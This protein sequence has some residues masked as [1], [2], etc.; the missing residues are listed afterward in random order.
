MKG[1][2]FLPGYLLQYS[3][4]VIPF[5]HAIHLGVSARQQALGFCLHSL[6]LRLQ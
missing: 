3:S 4:T 1:H 6:G 2:P 5:T